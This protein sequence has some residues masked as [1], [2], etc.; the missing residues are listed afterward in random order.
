[1]VIFKAFD[2]YLS[3]RKII[4]MILIGSRLSRLSRKRDKLGEID[5]NKDEE[6]RAERSRINVW[7]R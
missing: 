2:F 7:S 3:R 5:C 1:M 4:P 6:D